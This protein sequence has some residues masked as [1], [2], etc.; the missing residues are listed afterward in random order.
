VRLQ[1][2][3]KYLPDKGLERQ[4]NLVHFVEEKPM[5]R[6]HRIA[7]LLSIPILA[8]LIA[9]AGCS[10]D[11]KDGNAAADGKEAKDGKE[12][13]GGAGAGAITEVASTGTGTLKGKVTYDGDPPK[14]PDY[15]ERDDFK[16]H[17][18]KDLC[19]MG[20]TSNP[21]WKVGADKGVA[22]VVV[23]IRAPKNHFFKIP[24]DLKKLPDQTI[25]QPQC[26][27]EPHV[28]AVF[29]SYFDPATKK[30]KKTGQVFKVDNNAPKLHNT[31][32]KGGD[33]TLN[34]GKNET[35]KPGTSMVIDAVPGGSKKP[36]GEELISIHC[37][38]HKWMT[39]FARVFDHPYFAVTKEDGTYEIAKVPTGAEVEIVYW[40]EALGDP[41]VLKKVTLKPDNTEDIKVKK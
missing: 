20:D 12:K 17:A 3:P 21:T 41:N 4:Q 29:P 27:F 5:Q 31:A 11:N 36:G 38:L 14:L 24:D 1:P 34:P 22:N 23:W 25:K 32:W 37:D 6:L 2:R 13:G 40:H 35:L 9:T 7:L 33:S 39:G 28:V 8:V 10:K 30:Q 26:A 16:M 19:L 18:D 15:R